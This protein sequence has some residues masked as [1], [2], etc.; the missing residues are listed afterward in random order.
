M[1]AVNLGAQCPVRQNLNYDRDLPSLAPV[2]DAVVVRRWTTATQWLLM[3][4]AA[5]AGALAVNA[6]VALW[7]DPVPGHADSAL[8]R[9]ARQDGSQAAPAARNYSIILS[10]NLFGSEPIAVTE[11]TVEGA[12]RGPTRLYLRGTAMVDGTGY[13]VLENAASS[14]QDVFAVGEVVFD[15][16]RLE[17]V[18]PG[19]A[20]VRIDGQAVTLEI[21]EPGSG[22]ASTGERRADGRGAGGIRQT[23]TDTYLIDRREVDNAI[24]NLN[25]IVTQMRAV[26]YLKDGETLGFRVF[27][28]RRGS[29]FERI[30]LK[31]G[32]VIQKVNGASLDS[33]SKG[34]A[35][36]E[37]IQTT[38]EIRVDFLRKNEPSTLTYTIR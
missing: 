18:E 4:A 10:R 6:G 38:D 28:I 17:S 15:G 9:R 35:L 24:E 36:L 20:V 2:H 37:D 16:P 1:Q 11:D 7:M 12:P 29:L 31:D 13:A 26:P 34:L 30:G 22:K 19:R 32:D 3:A 5:Y 8:A 25:T 14:V 23:G 33:P 21:T 27:N